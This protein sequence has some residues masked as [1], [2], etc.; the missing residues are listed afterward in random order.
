[1]NLVTNS[2]TWKRRF[3]LDEVVKFHI[4]CIKK[5]VVDC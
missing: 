5:I 1:V 3:K 4:F 2:I